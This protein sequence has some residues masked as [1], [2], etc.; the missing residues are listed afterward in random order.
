MK[1]KKINK[2]VIFILVCTLFFLSLFVGFIFFFQNTIP[3]KYYGT[4][5]RYY[6]LDGNELKATYNISA[7][8]V[9][10]VLER[11]E[12]GKKVI[13]RENYKYYKKG[14]DL[15]IEIGEYEYYLIVDDDCLYVASSKDISTAKKYGNFYWNTKSVK[16][17]I[18]EI[19]NKAE[20]V[21][22]MIEKTM[23]AWVRDLIYDGVDKDLNDTNLYIINS[24]EKIDDTNLNIYEVVYDA[25]GGELHLYYNRKNRTLKRIYFFGSI[26]LNPYEVTDLDSMKIED[27]YDV[28]AMLLSLMYIFG[29]KEN[30]EL[31][32]DADN[33]KEYSKVLN[34]LDY[35][36]AVL[37]EYG[38]LFENK[39]VDE[40]YDDRYTYLLD[41]EKYDIE[42][43]SWI[44][45]SKYSATGLITFNINIKQ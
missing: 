19:K 43:M 18:Y 25:V 33:S 34:D 13:D 29:N 30:I 17:D 7:L 8:S 32:M 39:K 31:N 41:N 3:F 11:E 10:A 42:F 4:Y 44:S 28:R 15:I 12:N 45:Y 20:G 9:K 40:E 6:Y 35:R 22:S 14:N 24:D 23:N 2:K 37:E 26:F 5:V 21:D 1:N 27:I 36:I 16:A 38:K